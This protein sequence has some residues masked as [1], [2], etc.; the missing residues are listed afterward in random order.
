MPDIEQDK[1]L[2][3]NQQDMLEFLL[4]TTDKNPLDLK[5]GFGLENKK[6]R[7]GLYREYLQLSKLGYIKSRRRKGEKDIHEFWITDEGKKVF[8][9]YHRPKK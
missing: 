7:T 9:E 2:T 6:H 8:R 5:N 1:V 3:K 4:N